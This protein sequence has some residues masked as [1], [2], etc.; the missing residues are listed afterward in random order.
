MIGY[1]AQYVLHPRNSLLLILTTHLYSQHHVLAA[2]SGIK[3]QSGKVLVLLTES[4][5]IYCAIQARS[6]H[7]SLR[8]QR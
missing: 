4:G 3:M 2:A 5:L 8:R 7:T 6:P 1:T